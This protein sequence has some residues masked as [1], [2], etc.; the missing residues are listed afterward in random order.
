MATEY[1]RPPRHIDRHYANVS[2]ALGRIIGFVVIVSVAALF[3]TTFYARTPSGPSIVTS[4]PGVTSPDRSAPKV[5]T[6]PAPSTR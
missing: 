4:E 2:A 5:P 6:T 1:E 3:F